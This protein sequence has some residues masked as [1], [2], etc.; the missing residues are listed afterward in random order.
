MH[1]RTQQ[2]AQERLRG[3]LGDTPYIGAQ[4]VYVTKDFNGNFKRYYAYFCIVAGHMVHLNTLL[5]D[6]IDGVRYSKAQERGASICYG[7]SAEGDCDGLIRTLS[8]ILYGDE[9]Y[10]QTEVWK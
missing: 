9:N 8:K 6:A 2:E 1:F 10:I 3:R 7:H 5:Y 4:L